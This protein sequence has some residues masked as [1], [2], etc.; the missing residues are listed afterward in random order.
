M[1]SLSTVFGERTKKEIL[2]IDHVLFK[3]F[4]LPASPLAAKL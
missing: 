4:W 1:V 2:K 3:V